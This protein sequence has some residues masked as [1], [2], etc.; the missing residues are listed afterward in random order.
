MSDGRVYDIVV[1]GAS[2]FTGQYVVE[3]IVRTIGEEH[4]I[5][6]WAIAGREM[7]KLQQILSFVSKVTGQDVTELPIIIADVKSEQSLLDM[8]RQ[9]KVLLNCVGPYRFYGTAVVQACIESGT[10]HFDIS[11]ETEWLEKIQL[12]MDK[13]A[14]NREVFVVQACGFDSIPAEMG[15]QYTK[16]HFSGELNSVESFVKM[17]FGPEG[18]SFN[19]GTWKSAIHSLSTKS[20]LRSIREMIYP[21]ALPEPKYKLKKR[22]LLSYCKEVGG[23]C[24]PFLGTDKPIVQRTNYFNYITKKIQ[25]IQFY[26]YIAASGVGTLISWLFIGVMLF[27]FSKFK[28]G[29]YLLENYPR[30][31]SLG[32]FTSNGPT[33]AQ[34]K[35]STFEMTFIGE[36]YSTKSEKEPTTSSSPDKKIITKI[37]GPDPGYIA[38]PICLVQSA[39]ILLKERSKLSSQCGVFTPGRL[40][41]ESSLI[42]RLQKHNIIFSTIQE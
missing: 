26:P 23:Y 18:G 21:Q 27:V 14:R 4:G 41:S 17:Q 28:F 5:G 12:H 36:G 13:E 30:I 40:F 1:F 10:H 35:G 22:S 38:T 31:F 3:E 2:G 11:G 42:E 15:I 20:D 25:P 33:R 24:L 16:Q 8:C 6:K 37:V 34:V 32:M 39:Y 7:K 9:T 19:D 29:I